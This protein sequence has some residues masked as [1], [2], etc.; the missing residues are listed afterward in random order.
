MGNKLTIMLTDWI[1]NV[2]QT[3]R[4]DGCFGTG[5]YGRKTEGMVIK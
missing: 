3:T 4:P 5:K 2:Y 1:I